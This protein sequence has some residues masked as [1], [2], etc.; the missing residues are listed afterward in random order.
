MA[1]KTAALLD[2]TEDEGNP[3][4]RRALIKTGP[5]G[6]F[7][8]YV[9]VPADSTLAGQ[10]YD[11][12]PLRVHGGLTFGSEGGHG[13]PGGWYWYGWDYAH[14]GDFMDFAPRLGGHQWTVE[15][16][17]AETRQVMDQLRDLLADAMTD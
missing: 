12:V 13:W 15:E 6:S 2:W 11:D 14:S 10:P 3:L 7:C 16:V 9:G 5:C 1:M 17:E 4:A 8:A